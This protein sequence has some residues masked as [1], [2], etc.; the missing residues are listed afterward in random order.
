MKIS[1]VL[2]NKGPEVHTIDAGEPLSS[3][4]ARFGQSKLRC[5]VVTDG[6]ALAGM[7]TIRDALLH[8]D[9]RGSSGLVDPVREAMSRD[10]VAVT[11]ESELE[12]AHGFFTS[13]GITHLP[14]LAEGK[15]VGLVT[16]ADVL[17]SRVYDVEESNAHMLEY[18]SGS[19]L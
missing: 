8:L 16:R 12:Q 15:L 14:V 18:I 9:R 17:A 13:K 6:A 1:D 19:Y 2:A 7:L 5:L 11:P 3:A 10:V 4:V